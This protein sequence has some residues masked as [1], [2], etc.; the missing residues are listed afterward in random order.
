MAIRL[1]GRS[2]S[3]NGEKEARSGRSQTLTRFPAI[4]SL[5]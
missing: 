5:S 1:G 4:N 3:Q 2:S